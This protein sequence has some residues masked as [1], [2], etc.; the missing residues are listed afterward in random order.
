[1][2]KS[3]FTEKIVDKFNRMGQKFSHPTQEHSVKNSLKDLPFNPPND[4]DLNIFSTHTGIDKRDV[5]RIFDEH[6]EQNPDGKMDRKT[7]CE[8]YHALLQKEVDYVD[9]LSK[10]V[11]KALGVKD[12]DVDQITFN[13]FLATFILTSRGDFRKKI[14][15]VFDMHDIH[16]DNALEINEVKDI[17]AAILELYHPTESRSI[18]DIAKDCYKQLKITEVVRKG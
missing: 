15:Y 17:I 13:E 8:L 3:S 14:E 2:R 9:N 1:M 5:K 12:L 6:L 11:F 18:D 16:K 10:N 7:F 4:K